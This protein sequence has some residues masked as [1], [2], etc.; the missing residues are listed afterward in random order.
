MRKLDAL[1]LGMAVGWVAMADISEITTP[2]TQLV[3]WGAVALAAI[4][5]LGE[6]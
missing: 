4:L 2:A 5:V 1:L 3:G 6:A